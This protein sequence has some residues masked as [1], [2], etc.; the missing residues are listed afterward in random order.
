MRVRAG[1]LVVVGMAVALIAAVAGT[2]ADASRRS[3]LKEAGAG[4]VVA[5][6]RSAV[7]YAVGRTMHAC[8]YS[9]EHSVV[10]PNQG[11]MK[12]EGQNGSA[13]IDGKLVR[14]AGRYVG[15]NWYWQS[16]THS[17]HATIRQRIY[18]YDARFPDLKNRSDEHG[19]GDVGAFF[20]KHNGSAAWTFVHYLGSAGPDTTHVYKMDT[21]GDGEQELDASHPPLSSEENPYEI[22]LK[23]LA[24][25]ASG[26]RVYWTRDPGGV[27]TAAIR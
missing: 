24:L 27:Q 3:C 7:V 12:I 14:I 16:D 26:K 4:K 18:V 8:V 11:R 21:T 13:H 22:D 15:F 23:S 25:S 10:L 20:L 1:K 2:P 19:N 9:A 5:E 6:S 17:A